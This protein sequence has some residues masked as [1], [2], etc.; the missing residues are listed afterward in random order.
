MSRVRLP[1]SSQHEN[2][3]RRSLSDVSLNELSGGFVT[4][5][6]DMGEERERHRERRRERAKGVV[7][8]PIC[9]ADIFIGNTRASRENTPRRYGD[10]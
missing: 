3:Q 6:K 2:S 9:L 10:V 8:L 5:E 4:R 7:Y 1:V